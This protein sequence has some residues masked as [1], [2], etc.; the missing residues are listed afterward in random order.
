VILREVGRI[1]DEEP[2]PPGIYYNIILVNDTSP[3]VLLS[4]VI[5]PYK[6]ERLIRITII[7]SG[8]GYISK[9]STKIALSLGKCRTW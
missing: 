8:V 4:V 7:T 6:R 9:D 5:N 1:V 2:I 3:K